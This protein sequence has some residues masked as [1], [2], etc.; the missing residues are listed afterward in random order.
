MVDKNQQKLKVLVAICSPSAQA[1]ASFG[2]IGALPPIQ[3]GME[4]EIATLAL[5]RLERA[6]LVE[7]RI[8]PEDP[9][10]AVTRQMLLAA[11]KDDFHVLH[12]VCHGVFVGDNPPGD[13]FLAIE[14]AQGQPPFVGAEDVGVWMN[15]ATKLRLVVLA[16]CQSAVS[17]SG[18]A[19]AAWDPGWCS[20]ARLR[21]SSPCSRSCLSPLPSFSC[22]ASMTTWRAAAA[23][24]WPWS[25]PSDRL[26]PGRR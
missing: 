4:K 18:D 16:A 15:A 3:V 22:R 9:E 12:L 21:R 2:L 26:R 8:L 10:Q 19:L 25:H 24:T 6:G 7:K 14:G 11:V 20:T 13:Y 5:D 17:S 23:S 1:R